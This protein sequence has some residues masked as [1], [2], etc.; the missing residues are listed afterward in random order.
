M[1]EK[2]EANARRR[3]FF[4]SPE[5]YFLMMSLN[6]SCKLAPE[7]FHFEFTGFILPDLFYWEGLNS[8]LTTGKLTGI[9]TTLNACS[10]ALWQLL[11]VLVSTIKLLLNNKR[12]FC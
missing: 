8:W 9:V 5:K 10:V 11:Q 12:F 2:R 1:S 7:L 4:V 3:E 6:M